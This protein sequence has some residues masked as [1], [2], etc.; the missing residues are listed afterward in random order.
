MRM[1]TTHSKQA[2]ALAVSRCIFELEAEL[3]PLQARLAELKKEHALLFQ[4]DEPL[5]E[6]EPQ[7]VTAKIRRPAFDTLGVRVMT[8]LAAAGHE[9]TVNQLA[10]QLGAHAH[11]TLLSTLVT[12]T[13]EGRIVRVRTGVYALAVTSA[14]GH[15]LLEQG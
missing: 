10:A 7:P 2:R 13:R 8:V 5:P 3:K 15:P 12:L 6:P 11:Q 4:E 14:N 1:G 9:Q